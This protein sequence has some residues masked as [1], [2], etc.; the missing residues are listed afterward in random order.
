M[1]KKGDEGAEVAVLIDDLRRMGFQLEGGR[2]FD[3]TVKRSVEAFQV[4]KTDASGQPLVVDGKVGPNT[5]WA[6]DVFLGKI[7][8][9]ADIEVTLP[10]VPK[11]GSKSGRLALDV[12]IAEAVAGRGEEG[13]DNCGPD[14]RRYYSTHAEEGASWCAAFISYCFRE[15]LGREADFGYRIGAQDVHNQMRNLGNAYPASLQSPPQPGDIIVW[16]RVDPENPKGTAWQG[17]VGMVHGFQDGILWT[18]EGNRGPYPSKV[19]A[20]RYGW[21]DLVVSA[22]NDKFKGLYGLSRHP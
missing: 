2:T 19:K 5:R 6:I 3:A 8:T 21:S 1:L 13:G 9:A 15:A 10:P 20:F 14:I 17:H 7:T 4:G 11:G 16:R 18:I 22:G 12:A